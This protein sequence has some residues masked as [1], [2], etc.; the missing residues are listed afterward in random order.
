MSYAHSYFTGG[1]NDV[2]VSGAYGSA[3]ANTPFGAGVATSA[4]Y[5]G[6]ETSYRFNTQLVLVGLGIVKRSQRLILV[7]ML[8]KVIRQISGTGR[9]L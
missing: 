3:F 5:Y 6:I 1:N 2:S 9:S 8:I 7:Q 4:N